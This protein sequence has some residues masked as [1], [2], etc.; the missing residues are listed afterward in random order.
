[1]M[2]V[3]VLKAA[4]GGVGG[5]VAYYAGRAKP[6]LGEAARGPVDY[7]LDPEEPPGRWWGQGRRAHGLDGEVAATELG[8]LFEGR[9][10]GS[11]EPLGRAFSVGSVRGF[12]ATFS[13]PK[14]VS[15]LWALSPDP[16]VRQPYLKMLTPDESLEERLSKNLL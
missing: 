7:Y 12:D 6:G 16:W 2:R 3:T 15:L 4:P 11:E 5:L 9:A 1:M 10:P 13:A 8:A 14:S